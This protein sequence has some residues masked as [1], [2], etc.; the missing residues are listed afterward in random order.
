M[1]DKKISQLPSGQ[2]LPQTIFPIVT[3]GTTSQTSYGG[4]LNAITSDL[5]IDSVFTSATYNNNTGEITLNYLNG[6]STTLSGFFTASDDV[7]VTGGTYS[8]GTAT[9]TNNTGGTFSVSGF[10]TGGDTYWESGNT[11]TDIKRIASGNIA[12]GGY[13]AAFGISSVASGGYSAAFNYLTKASGYASHAEGNNTQ[14]NGDFSHAEGFETQANGKSS[15]AEGNYTQALGDYSHTQGDSTQ[16]LGLGSYAGGS[17][18]VASGYTSFAFGEDSSAL[19]DY[20][21]V[22]G[23]SITGTTSNTTYVDKLNIKTVGVYAD[24]AAATAAGLAVGAIY[25]TSEGGLMIRY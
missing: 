12:S 11:A 15:H 17:K 10:Y 4:L 1:A 22:L 5:A 13:S 2:I 18:T 9:F 3:N 24:N 16:A 25:R 8:D 6:G 19:A 21:V 7:F 14:A 20:T 23:K